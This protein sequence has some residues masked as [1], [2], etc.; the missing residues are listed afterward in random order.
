MMN[1]QRLQAEM[2]VL[3]QHLKS[4]TY[5]F[6]DMGTEHPYLTVG[7][8]TNSGHVYTL[9]IMLE[10]F[11]YQIPPVCVMNP[12]R[13]KTGKKLCKPD[14]NMHVLCE[15]DGHTQICHYGY[16]SWKAD[17]SLYKVF[18]KCRL[19]LEMYEEHLRTGRPIDYYLKHQY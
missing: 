1:Q 8:M 9:K 11:P 16:Y 5:Q 14:G 18:M 13:S 10:D 12:L 2:T 17:V 19:W 4:N 7:A 6:F 3:E 15:I